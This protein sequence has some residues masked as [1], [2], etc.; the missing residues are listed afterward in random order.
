MLN[1]SQEGLVSKEDFH[2][3]YLSIPVKSM[4]E[5]IVSEAPAVRTL[6]KESLAFSIYL[7]IGEYLNFVGLTMKDDVILKV[8][9]MMI[10]CQPN[11]PVDTLK[12]FF[13]NC[14]RGLYGAHYNRMDGSTLLRWYDEF[15]NKFLKERE[16]Y[17]Y[18]QHLSR[19]EGVSTP[20]KFGE[21]EELVSVNFDELYE[22]F[23]GQPRKKA[24]RDKCIDDIRIRV[25]N[26]NL[27][28]YSELSPQEAETRI[29]ELIDAEIA[30]EI[31]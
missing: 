9:N 11:M 3:Q 16:E 28:L 13:F 29:N 19:K 23:T 18:Q 6:N 25:I 20:I 15:C 14:E 10:E 12:L 24:E 21:D 1:N 4:D 8:A 26:A 2:R 7:A 31:V 17:D 27:R 5:L 30:K 22:S